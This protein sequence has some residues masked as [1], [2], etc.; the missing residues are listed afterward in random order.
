M[1]LV[2]AAREMLLDRMSEMKWFSTVPGSAGSLLC[3]SFKVFGAA[4]DK[5]LR[6][7]SKP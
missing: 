4:L 3:P 6:N 7:L 2:T 1:L 5:V